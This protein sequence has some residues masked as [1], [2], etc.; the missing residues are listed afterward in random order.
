MG[1][2][3][4]T[5]ILPSKWIFLL[6]FRMKRMILALIL[7]ENTYFIN[8]I[9]ELNTFYGEEKTPYLTECFNELTQ[10]IEP[11]YTPK[12]RDSFKKHLETFAEKVLSL[13]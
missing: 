3:L 2:S 9:K 5:H 11:T 1:R 4:N 10:K 13:K 8:M 7:I 6:C 12:C